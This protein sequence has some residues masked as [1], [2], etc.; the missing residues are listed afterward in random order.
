MRKSILIGCSLMLAAC[1]GSNSNYS[2]A[3]KSWEG[4]SAHELVA[5]WGKPNI[6]STLANGNTTYIYKHTIT[7]ATDTE[8]SPRIGVDARTNAT[9]IITGMP[10]VNS[11]N[12]QTLTTSCTA[13]FTASRSGKIISA[14][15][16]GS[17]CNIGRGN[18]RT[19]INT[20][21]K[22]S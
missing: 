17:S 5:A 18:A 3:I 22:S 9:P 19:L 2:D 1:A 13:T 10:N 20:K 12:K 14:D 8:Y 6:Q 21:R 11:P 7:T 4:G 16:D 15:Y